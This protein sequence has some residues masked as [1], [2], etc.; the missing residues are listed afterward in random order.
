MC[1]RDRGKGVR[2]DVDYLDLYL[3]KYLHEGDYEEAQRLLAGEKLKGDI[4]IKGDPAE[5][6]PDR[7]IKE[8]D[9][10]VDTRGKGTYFHGTSVE[11]D[12]LDGPADA[13]YYQEGGPGLFG[14]GFY[15]T[16]D[17]ITAIKYKN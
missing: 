16:D 15:T 6:F 5:G 4:V 13:N 12:K 14:Y 1:I 7:T 11:I 8:Q 10:I 3:R 9:R 2:A 17:I